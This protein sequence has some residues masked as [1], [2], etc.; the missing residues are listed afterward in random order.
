MTYKQFY[1]HWYSRI[2][3]F[4]RGY[5]LS[6]D[7]AEDIVQ[8]IFLDLFEKY[9]SL[10]Y[11]VNIV[12][13]I[14][15]TAKNRCIDHLRHQIVVQESAKQIREEHYLT[16][17]M[18]F[19]SLEILNSELF[20]ENHIEE[21]INKALNTLPDRCREIF[22]KHKID[23]KKRKEIALELGLS[24]KTIENQLTIA[25]KKLRE[26]LKDHLPLLILLALISY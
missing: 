18:K 10:V 19:D 3:H 11:R 14:F 20:S 7:D 23:G 21:I 22:I 5:V 15:T 26:E 6:E 16:M 13:Y 1:I 24:P 25:Y 8:D 2:K 17:R 9:D 4:V 12:A